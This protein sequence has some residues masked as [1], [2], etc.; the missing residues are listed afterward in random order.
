MMRER[1]VL[2]TVDRVV[3]DAART[4]G[5]TR[6]FLQLSLHEVGIRAIRVMRGLMDDLLE[7]RSLDDVYRALMRPGRKVYIGLVLI[8]LALCVYFVDV[9]S[10]SPSS[11]PSPPSSS[12]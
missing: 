8:V 10:S 3:N 5:D 1:R 2:D 12:S 6:A 4:D 7:S 11:S 9:S